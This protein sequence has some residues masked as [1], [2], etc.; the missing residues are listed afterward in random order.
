MSSLAHWFR[1]ELH[2]WRETTVAD[3]SGGQTVT[4]VDQGALWFKVDQ[5][6]AAERLAAAQAGAKH[7][8][9]IY[10]ETA[11]D[12]LRNDRLAAV[13]VDPNAPQAGD[14]IYAVIAGDIEPSTPIYQKIEAERIEVGP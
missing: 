11:N 13:G 8:N 9:N 5:S 1:R 7:T 12:V 6:S 4:Y 14:R 10:T 2:V 3:G